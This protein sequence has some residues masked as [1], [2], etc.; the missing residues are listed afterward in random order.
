MHAD[1]SLSAAVEVW[2]DMP[3]I[4]PAFI[5]L[6]VS[7]FDMELQRLS[8]KNTQENNKCDQ[9]TASESYLINK[10]IE[11]Q[12][13]I[14]RKSIENQLKINRKSLEHQLKIN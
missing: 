13:K 4:C 12:L 5:A 14:N 3:R 7:K 2:P 1:A 6:S 8:P 10:E 9:V 11:N